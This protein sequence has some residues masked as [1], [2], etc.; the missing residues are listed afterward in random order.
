MGTIHENVIYT[1]IK[2][3]C[4]SHTPPISF[5]KMCVDLGLSKSLGTK[6]KDNPDKEI[7]SETAQMIADYFKV[8]V[9]RVLGNE[10]KEEPT[11][12]TTDERITLYENI[13][14]L[15]DAKGI[16]PGKM[17]NDTQISR[18]LITD[19]KMGRKSSI[20]VDTAQKIADYF[21]VSVDCVLGNEQKETSTA[22]SGERITFDDFTYAMQNEAK[23]LTDMDKQ[24]LLSMA[25]QLNDARKQ[26]DG[27]RK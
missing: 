24:L 21:G 14:N 3:L 1:S 27:E 17:C 25:K 7:N 20:T 23:D 9:D 6:L 5:S 13:I 15:C 26:K 4:D 18:G 19:L 22:D 8:S 11:S 10:Q 2:S 16:K 12:Q